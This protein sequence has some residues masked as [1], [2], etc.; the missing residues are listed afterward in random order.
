MFEVLSFEDRFFEF[1]KNPFTVIFTYYDD[2]LT[3]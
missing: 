1:F 2:M 3:L